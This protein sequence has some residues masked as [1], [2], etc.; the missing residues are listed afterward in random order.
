MDPPDDDMDKRLNENGNPASGA[1][2]KLVKEAIQGAAGKGGLKIVM[3]VV[4]SMVG[5]VVL[6]AL[7]YIGYVRMQ[8]PR[9]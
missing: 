9:T 6:V 1:M 7:G 5:L 2:S 3:A 8:R 4:G